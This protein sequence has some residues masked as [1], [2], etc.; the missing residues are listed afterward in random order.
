MAVKEE[1]VLDAGLEYDE[2]RENVEKIIESLPEKRKLIFKLSRDQ[3]LSNPEI[4]S[5]LGLSVKTVEDHIMH[6][7]K[8]IRKH[9]KNIE[10]ITLLYI[11]IF[12]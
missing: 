10:I 12:L 7:L 11:A 9:L 3:G 1:L 4:A 2:L 6:S 5:Q 8:H